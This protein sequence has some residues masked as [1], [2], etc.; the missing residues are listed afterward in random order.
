MADI[1]LKCARKH[2]RV[3]EVGDVMVEQKSCSNCKSDVPVAEGE[4]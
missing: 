2:F 1:C 3:L 4:Q